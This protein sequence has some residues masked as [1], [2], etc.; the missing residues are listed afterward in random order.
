MKKN[1]EAMSWNYIKDISSIW[2]IT[3]KCEFPDWTQDS[4]S[5]DQY[6]NVQN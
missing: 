2:I 5:I 4:L 3:Y 6:N 1:C